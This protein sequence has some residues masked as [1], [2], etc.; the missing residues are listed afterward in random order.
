MGQCGDRE[1]RNLTPTHRRYRGDMSKPKLGADIFYNDGRSIMPAKITAVHG[2][3]TVSL[4]AFGVS[5]T[6]NHTSKE[7][8]P[9]DTAG[10]WFWSLPEPKAEAP[11]SSPAPA[12][13]T[14]AEPTEEHASA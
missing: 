5:S 8:G 13:A 10:K 14:P 4:V 12:T 11:K 1:K 7:L 3:K 6:S 9:W 2:E